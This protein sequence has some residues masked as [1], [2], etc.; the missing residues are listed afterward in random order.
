LSLLIRD[1]RKTL[2]EYYVDS[3]WVGLHLLGG[4]EAV[5]AWDRQYVYLLQEVDFIDKRLP[6]VI[7]LW[8]SD[9][10]N[11]YLGGVWWYWGDPQHDRWSIGDWSGGLTG[12][13]YDSIL[14]NWDVIIHQPP[15]SLNKSSLHGILCK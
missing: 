13:I 12:L 1:V 5:V 15:E 2:V 14:N 10:N 8:D 11:P 3:F 4:D 6:D 9:K 7:S